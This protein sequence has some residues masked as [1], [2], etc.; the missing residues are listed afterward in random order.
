MKLRHPTR[1][2]LR[3]ALCAYVSGDLEAAAGQ[4]GRL[5]AVGKDPAVAY[6]L[7]R[8]LEEL[9]RYDAARLAIA[10]AKAR[11]RSCQPC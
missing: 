11:T 10:D 8:V 1:W 2:W 3:S 5:H 6:Y 7:A 9:G 4:L